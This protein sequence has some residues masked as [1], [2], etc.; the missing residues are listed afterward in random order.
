M[1]FTRLDESYFLMAASLGRPSFLPL[2]AYF[3]KK[4]TMQQGNFLQK[5]AGIVQKTGFFIR[6]EFGKNYDENLIFNI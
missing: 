4:F 3:L 6:E 1:S 2:P 5:I